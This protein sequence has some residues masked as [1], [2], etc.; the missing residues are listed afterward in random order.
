MKKY[1]FL[2]GLMLLTTILV[3]CK[4][5]YLEVKDN[6]KLNRQ[7][8]VKDLNSM[9]E[10][11]KGVYLMLSVKYEDAFNSLYPALV[12]DDLKVSGLDLPFALHYNWSQVSNASSSSNGNCMNATWMNLYNIIRACSFVIEDINK[13]SNENL[14][15]ANNL[16]GQAYAIRALVHLA[17]VNIFAQHYSF[18]ADAS[19]LGIPYITTFD[20]SKSYHRQTVAEV[21]RNMITDLESAVSL[22]PNSVSDT[23]YMNR[24]AAKA[25]LCRIYLY[26]EEYQKAKDL[27]TG[28]AGLHPLMSINDGYPVNMFKLKE[29]SQ[30][31]VLFQITPSNQYSLIAEAGSI[32][33]GLY[34]AYDDYMATIDV[35]TILKENENDIRNAWVTASGNSWKVT[36]FP[37]GVAGGL[38]QDPSIDYYVPAIRSSEM[39]LIAA[40]ACAKTNDEAGARLYLNAVRKRADPIVSDIITSGQDLLDLIYKERRKELCF[41]GFRMWDL[42]RW[43]QGVHRIDV[44]PGS[45]KDLPYPSDRAISPIPGQ[46]VNLMGL[47]QNGGY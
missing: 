36:K 32:F 31:E 17:L 1:K 24:P 21:Y 44:F 33:L 42:Q 27:A 38:G 2:I 41:E 45:Q 46:D 30:T 3:S 13:Y 40:E 14:E 15:K 29:P 23:R 11:M 4:K 6:S 28:L 26:Q 18:T 37:A 9:E 16:K 8:Y 22:M 5:G 35:A 39:F 10:Y 12:A 47:Q 25:L 19:H 7:S 34:L 43:K 20:I